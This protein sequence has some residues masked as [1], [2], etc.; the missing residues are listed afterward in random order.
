MGEEKYA[1]SGKS[2][3]VLDRWTLGDFQA[4]SIRPW[5]EM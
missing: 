3:Y 5:V 2:F 1:M 4:L